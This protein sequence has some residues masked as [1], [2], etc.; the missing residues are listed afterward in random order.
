MKVIFHSHIL[1]LQA[2]NTHW[3]H[4]DTRSPR[5]VQSAPDN[6]M[7]GHVVERLWTTLFSCTKPDLLDRCRQN[8]CACF[9]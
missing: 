2:N 5:F 8:Q 6:P 9:D 7:F 3:I 1:N 4:G